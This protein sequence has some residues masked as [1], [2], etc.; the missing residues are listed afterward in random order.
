MMQAATTWAVTVVVGLVGGCGGDS[1]DVTDDAPSID[2]AAAIDGA[3]AGTPDAALVT[4]PAEGE[5]TVTGSAG[6]LVVEPT[7]VLGLPA[8]NGLIIGGPGA[9]CLGAGNTPYLYFTWCDVAPSAGTF[10]VGGDLACPGG[11]IYGHV[12]L[13]SSITP[14]TGGTVT[15]EAATDGCTV[16]TFDVTFADGAMSGTF[17][18]ATCSPV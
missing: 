18:A 16:G 12:A 8:E 17:S 2:A 11:V 9:S 1:G 7:A 4:C 13:N 15:I 10:T 3:P 14:V 6:K 5:A